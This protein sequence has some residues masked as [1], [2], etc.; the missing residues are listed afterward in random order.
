[1]V[2]QAVIPNEGR[3]ARARASLRPWRAARITPLTEL[4]QAARLFPP[5]AM[6]VTQLALTY[7]LWH[8][9]YAG[10]KVSAG[11]DVTQ[12]TT[13]AM[14]GVLYQQFSTVE[15]WSNGDAMVQLMTEGTIAFW[16]VRPVSA[17]RYYLI[18]AVGDLA[19]GGGLAL[20]AYLACLGIGAIALPPS[21]PAAGA[22]LVTLVFGVAITYYLQLILNLICFWSTVNDAAI[23][24]V[25]FTTGL[26]S[27][28][29]APLWF[30]PGWFQ[31]INAFLPF[32]TTLNAPLSLYVGR[33]PVSDLG[34]E[35]AV[36]AAWTAGLALF[37]WWLWRRAAARVTVLGG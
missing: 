20:V 29:F 37:T 23:T 13:F 16:F 6:V 35:L 34:A 7:W 28:A 1:M 27:G 24:V 25:Q 26:L 19:Y 18:R 17:R 32:Q 8:A 11:L 12:A 22:A 5:V 21:W 9:L 14:L 31:D 2:Q 3:L 30:F 4:T 10:V 33:L 36:Q 15:R